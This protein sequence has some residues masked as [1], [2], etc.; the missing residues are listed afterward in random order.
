M[1]GAVV[2]ENEQGANKQAPQRPDGATAPLEPLESPGTI[3]ESERPL[4]ARTRSNRVPPRPR[5]ESELSERGQKQVDQALREGRLESPVWR[6]KR[7]ITPRK[8][9]QRSLTGANRI[10]AQRAQADELALIKR[11]LVGLLRRE[12]EALR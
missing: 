3:P 9:A 2:P 8:G 12:K 1:P 4:A 10:R 11:S 7:P 6:L 5:S